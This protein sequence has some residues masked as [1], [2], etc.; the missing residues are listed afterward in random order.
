M[1]LMHSEA[2]YLSPRIGMGYD[3]IQT[4]VKKTFD[5]FKNAHSYMPNIDLLMSN[6][7]KKD[8][9]VVEIAL[10]Y[11]Y[12]RIPQAAIESMQLIDL[13]LTEE[14]IRRGILYDPSAKAA[15]RAKAQTLDE[16]G[17]SA[18]ERR[19]LQS[20]GI[21]YTTPEHI[22]RRVRKIKEKVA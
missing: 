12:D 22:K 3:D 8:A 18:A 7:A 17:F 1:R 16:N 10:D 6:L 2:W 21:L 14:S 5:T 19:S 9:N 13:E 11:Y 15:I 4:I 20:R